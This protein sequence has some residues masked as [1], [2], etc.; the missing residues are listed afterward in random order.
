MAVYDPALMLVT[1]NPVAV[2]YIVLKALLAIALWGAA[3]SGFLL[4]HLVPAERLLAAAAAFLLVAA[5]PVTDEIGFALAFVT[6]VVH[7]LR[8][9][10]SARA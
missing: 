4:V 8:A 10:R 7:G 1:D 9:R 6:I 5:L 2:A 3:A